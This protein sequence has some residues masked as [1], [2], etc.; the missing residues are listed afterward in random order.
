MKRLITLATV[1]AG[2]TLSSDAFAHSSSHSH[3]SEHGHSSHQRP[4]QARYGSIRVVN[5][6]PM[7]VLVELEDGRTRR[8]EAR[9]ETIFTGVP[10]RDW[11]VAIRRTSG[12]LLERVDLRVQP[13]RTTTTVVK[14][15]EL[16][17]VVID[18]NSSRALTVY[19]NGRSKGSVGAYDRMTLQLGPSSV[20]V[21]LVDEGGRADILVRSEELTVDLFK[22]A[23]LTQGS[24]AVANACH[25]R[26]R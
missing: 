23:R 22:T 25:A 16:G 20:R 9:Q 8:V 6:L 4:E 7:A 3:G 24:Q 14:P 11:D 18:N 13:D 15:P 19:V 12:E 5:P 26:P 1:L 2:L 17:L 21:D 10:V